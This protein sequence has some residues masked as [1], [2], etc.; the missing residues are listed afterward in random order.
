MNEQ[1]YAVKV[2]GNIVYTGSLA[3]CE[4]YTQGMEAGSYEIIEF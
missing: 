1:F 2:S 4:W 3:E